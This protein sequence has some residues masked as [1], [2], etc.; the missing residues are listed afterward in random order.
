[1]HRLEDANV[2]EPVDESG[3]P[4]PPGVT[5]SKLYVT[6]VL[7]KVLPII[8]YE[9]D[10][11]PTFLAEPNPGPWTGRRVAPITGRAFEELTY[12]GGID[13]DVHAI[14]LIMRELPE[15]LE[16]QYRQTETGASIDVAL[17][18]PVDLEP[19]RRSLVEYLERLGLPN[20]QVT[21]QIVEMVPRNPRT[22][23][24]TQ[25]VALGARLH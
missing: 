8:R 13:V 9:L 4:V 12:P 15:L 1:M 3:R 6:N 23:K 14:A 24:I 19:T 11:A 2:V 20:P 21:I 18:G 22:G 17:D 16:Y 7:N 25:F 5:A 10:D